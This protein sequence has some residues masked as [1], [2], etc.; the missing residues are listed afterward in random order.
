VSHRLIAYAT[1]VLLVA[2]A[3]ATAWA[4]SSGGPAISQSPIQSLFAGL[5]S[6]LIAPEHLMFVLALGATAAFVRAMLLIPAAFIAAAVLGVIASVPA[7]DLIT[8]DTLIGITLIVLGA[9]F[10]TGKNPP[11]P[12]WIAFALMAGVV[13]GL[14]YGWSMSAADRAGLVTYVIGLSGTHAVLAA[15]MAAFTHNFIV[16]DAFAARRMKAAGGALIAMGLL[17]AATAW[18]PD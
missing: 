2:V 9:A 3:A 12:A 16:L 17:F 5:K 11:T 18:T 13:H 14:S 10:L 7:I 6:P 15:A 1:T 8:T 4:Q